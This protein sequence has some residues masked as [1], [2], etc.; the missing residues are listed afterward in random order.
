[1][2][3]DKRLALYALALT[4]VVEECNKRQHKQNVSVHAG[5]ILSCVYVCIVYTVD[6]KGYNLSKA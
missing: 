5:N 2:V 6:L 3:R 1:M 4:F